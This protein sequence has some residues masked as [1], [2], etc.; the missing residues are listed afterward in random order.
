M[1]HPSGLTRHTEAHDHYVGTNRIHFIDESEVI[2]VVAM[3]SQYH[4]AISR[5]FETRAGLLGET[6]SAANQRQPTWPTK[7]DAGA[8]DNIYADVGRRGARDAPSACHTCETDNRR[9]IGVDHVSG[10]E[11][12]YELMVL[13]VIESSYVKG[14]CDC[15]LAPPY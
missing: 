3:L 2:R 7:C 1:L 8:A 13:T 5:P 6:F 14:V 9:A 15:S 11:R 10:V 4:F 12:L